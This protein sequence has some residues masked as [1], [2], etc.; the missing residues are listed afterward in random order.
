[1]RRT[2]RNMAVAFMI[3]GSAV[4]AQAKD[5]G[6]YI[7]TWYVVRTMD[8]MN[9]SVKDVSITRDTEENYILAL[10]CFSKEPEAFVFPAKTGDKFEDKSGY[11]IKFRYDQ[12]S[13]MDLTGSAQSDG[14]MRLKL[15]V[16][17]IQSAISGN[18]LAFRF[19]G[20]SE[21][22]SSDVPCAVFAVHLYYLW[23]ILPERPQ[24]GVVS[25]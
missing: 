15:P 4:A 23:S 16:K 20:E 21:S 10:R 24:R 8:N 14:S 1:M 2:I 12:S 3:V 25:R 6:R 22:F 13:P 18:K 5:A 17:I 7:G 19:S 11:K 9:D